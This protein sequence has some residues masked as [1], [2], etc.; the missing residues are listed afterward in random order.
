MQ[1]Y[2]Q[3]GREFLE[4][5]FQIH[6]RTST[7]Q[8]DVEQGIDLVGADGTT[9]AARM[10]KKKQWFKNGD[11][12]LGKSELL[13]ILK[14]YVD[15]YLMCTIR[16]KDKGRKEDILYGGLFDMDVWRWQMR[17]EGGDP[18]LHPDCYVR[19]SNEK[20][21]ICFHMPRMAKRRGG[22]GLIITTMQDHYQPQLPL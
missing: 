2:L 1:P 3:H 12:V 10:L 20:P 21:L 11:L 7:E 15:I 14:G 5:K 13:K 8:E 19:M 4:S 6:Y 17:I 22:Q 18:S 16:V 9:A